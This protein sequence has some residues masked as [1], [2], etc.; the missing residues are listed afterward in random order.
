LSRGRKRSHEPVTEQERAASRV[1]QECI[2]FFERIL[3]VGFFQFSNALQAT[4]VGHVEDRE[5]ST[6]Q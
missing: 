2:D 4:I 1:D 3:K 6:M 5:K